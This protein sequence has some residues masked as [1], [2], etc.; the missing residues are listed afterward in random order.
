MHLNYIM[1]NQKTF[2]PEVNINKKI[3]K[4]Y[5]YFSFIYNN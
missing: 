1:N 2:I 3:K 5:Y 4:F